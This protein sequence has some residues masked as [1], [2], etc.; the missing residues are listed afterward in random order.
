LP[1]V[2]TVVEVGV[3][4]TLARRRPDIREAEANLHAAT[5]EVGVAVA[6]FYPDISLTGNVGMRALDASYLTN[7]ASHFYSAGPAISL[8]I[9]SGGQ[10]AANLTLA[11]AQQ[12]SSALNYRGTV[13]NA[14]REVE[15]ALVAYRTDRASRDLLQATLNSAE[16]TW[17][18][19]K[20]QYEHGLASFITALD[21]ERTVLSDRQALVQ[22]D[23]Q[24]VNDIV[25]L[26][27]ALGG[28]WETTVQQL[29]NPDVPTAPPPLPAA[30]DRVGATAP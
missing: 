4:S 6:S 10:L 14:L 17:T 30:L 29:P 8:P 2:P 11:R 5:A 1:Q 15:D 26:Y 16:L 24:I 22:A 3:P 27:R 28:G 23:V 18:L 20:S 21:A 19:S 25:T 13:L 9:F 12:Q 7:W